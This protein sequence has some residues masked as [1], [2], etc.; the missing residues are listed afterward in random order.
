MPQH[1][2]YTG[3]LSSIDR[4]LDLAVDAQLERARRDVADMRRADAIDAEERREKARR[5][6]ERCLEHQRAYDDSFQKFGRRAP[7]PAA[8]DRARDYRR[9]LYA[10]GQ[11]MLP[12]GHA[13]TK[14]DPEDIDGTAIQPLEAQLLEALDREATEPTGDNVPGEGEPLR[15][16]TKIDSATGGKKTEFYGES[17]I[18]SLGRP[19]R[20]VRRLV[21]PRNGRVLLGQAWSTPPG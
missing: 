16:I 21:D 17:F 13:L 3:R 4:K 12:S 10:I 19:G 6:A 8:D 2:Y 1:D 7:A 20:K 11:S 5:D 9:R 14:F 18:K 15:E